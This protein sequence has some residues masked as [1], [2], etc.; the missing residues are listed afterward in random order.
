MTNIKD[1][2]DNLKFRYKKDLVYLVAS[3]ASAGASYLYGNSFY[4]SITRLSSN[5]EHTLSL[6]ILSECLVMATSG[7]LSAG[8]GLFAIIKGFQSLCEIEGD[9]EHYFS[10]RR[11]EKE[12]KNKN[13]YKN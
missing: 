8:L 9:A 2:R 13:G 10:L 11:F 7:A 3:V 12:E 1:S 5:S 4:E 6:N